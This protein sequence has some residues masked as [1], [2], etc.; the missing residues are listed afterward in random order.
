MN[1]TT[2]CPHCNTRFRITEAQ[3]NA[4]H[5]MVR[6]GHCQAA[7]DA[8]IDYIA[9]QSGLQQPVAESESSENTAASEQAN[10]ATFLGDI[11][12]SETE[13]EAIVNNGSDES[14]HHDL[15]EQNILAESFEFEDFN[16]QLP[17]ADLT[18]QPDH[19]DDQHANSVIHQVIEVEASE[20]QPLKTET[21]ESAAQPEPVVQTEAQELPEHKEQFEFKELPEHKEQ[22]EHHV[23]PEH[24]ELPEQH[25]VQAQ[26]KRRTWPWMLGITA[27]V[28]LLTAQST[29][30][31]RIELAARL[32]ALKPAL[33]GVCR[34]LGCDLPLPQNADLISIESSGLDADPEHEN[35]ITLNALLRSRASYNVS[36]PVLALTLN[37]SHDSPMA[38]RW[39]LPSEYLPSGESEQSGFIA[40]HEVN[41]KLHLDTA[42]LKPSGYRLELFYNNKRS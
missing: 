35:L 34:T 8:R 4:H 23:L 7:F 24:Y 38:R 33:V 29:Y 5:G 21:P 37:D 2:S 27:S 32:P 3:L 12:S 11:A 1:G 40:N 20:E 41:I 26:L 14:S 19:L 39:L 31:F 9:E 13:S 36:F 10:L 16:L 30:F 15:H 42:D 28:L 17:A 18:H 22:F 25:Q 6:C